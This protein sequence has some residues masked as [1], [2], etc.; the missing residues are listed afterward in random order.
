LLDW[1]DNIF[2]C[3]FVPK[4]LSE[5]GR[6]FTLVFTGGGGGKDNDSLNTVRGAFELRPPPSQGPK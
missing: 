5:D 4:W 2:F 1:Q 6:N 3:A